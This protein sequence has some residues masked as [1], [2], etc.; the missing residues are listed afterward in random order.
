MSI[1][2]KNIW[3]TGASSGIGEACAYRYARQGTNLVLTATRADKLVEVREECIRL[4]AQCTILPYDLTDLEHIDELT[5]K[6]V[7]AFGKI[8]IVFLNAGIS[9]RS[10][11]LETDGLVDEKIMTVNFFAPVKIAKRLLPDMIEQ[12]GGTIAV[13]SSISGKFG[14]PLR[15]AYASSKFA[16]YGFFETLHAEYY[17]RNI[18]VVMV[19]PGR[20][21]TNISYN[22]LEADGRKHARMDE[23]QD[24]GISADKAAKKIVNAIEKRKPEVLVGGKE[25]LMVHIKRFFPGLARKMVRKIKTT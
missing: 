1:K 10:K 9:Q 21:K 11:I 25:L 18:R 6:A 5:D 23:G 13:T 14:F 20:I 8:D 15:S 16:L 12:Q 19:C 22:A 24:N 3:I 17:D 4:G 7:A 2:R